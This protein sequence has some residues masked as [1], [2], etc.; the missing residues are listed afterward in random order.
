VG[1]GCSA[2]RD[3]D[4]QVLLPG[5]QQNR[6]APEH[7]IRSGALRGFD[8]EGSDVAHPVTSKA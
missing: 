7:P 6:S 8:V 4:R 3:D 5:T 1:A 2:V